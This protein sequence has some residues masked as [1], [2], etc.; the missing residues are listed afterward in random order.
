MK[1]CQTCDQDLE[2]S[3]ETCPVCNQ[4]FAFDDG[5]KF[6]PEPGIYTGISWAD[7]CRIPYMNPST[8]KHGLRSMKRLKRAIDGEMAPPNPKTVAVGNAVHAFLSGEFNER[9]IE[10]PPFETDDE[11]LTAGTAKNPPKSMIKQDGSPSAAGK[12]WIELCKEHGKPDD[13]KDTITVS[14]VKTQS[15]TTTYYQNKVAEFERDNESKTI[16]TSVQV[17]TAR[18]VIGEIR[19][20]KEADAVLSHSQHELTVIARIN[21]LLCKTRI[22]IAKP[23]TG[24]VCDI[25]TTGDIEPRTFYRQA[26]K[27]GYFFQ[28]AFHV[29]ALA[30]APGGWQVQE[31]KVLAAEVGDD[32]DTGLINIPF[33]LID[34]WQARVLSKIEDYRLA[35]AAGI[36]DGLYKGGC[37]E[38]VVPEYEMVEEDQVQWGE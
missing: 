26:K 17:A 34:Q 15:K 6:L 16:L 35:K 8:L 21:G 24:L 33:A 1:F 36:Y 9:F 13:F 11:N 38:L 12:K 37:G 3:S 31:Y 4:D 2:A 25:K 7:Y 10:M 23:Q 27:M 19:K 29:E 30:N 5:E 18:K 22:D 20:N 32:Y 28:F 14:Q